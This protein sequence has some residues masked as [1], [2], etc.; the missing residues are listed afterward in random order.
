[1]V[2]TEKNIDPKSYF[3]RIPLGCPTTLP[4]FCFVV[5][6]RRSKQ[7]TQQ[8]SPHYQHLS[9]FHLYTIRGL[10]GWLENTQEMGNMKEMGTTQT[11]AS[12]SVHLLFFDFPL[13][14]T[15]NLSESSQ[16]GQVK[17]FWCAGWSCILSGSAKETVCHLKWTLCPHNGNIWTKKKEIQPQERSK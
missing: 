9:G 6:D 12:H 11:D 17:L 7:V 10:T 16:R 3:K 8:V 2:C 14:P 15:V 4:L 1:M 5:P 13:K